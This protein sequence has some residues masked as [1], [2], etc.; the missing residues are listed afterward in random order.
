MVAVIDP[1]SNGLVASLAR[2][3]ANVTGITFEV[4]REQAGKNLELLKEAVPTVSRVAILRN[5]NVR[6]HMAY[7]NEAERAAKRLGVTIQFAEM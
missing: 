5:P 4:T 1:V 3:G 2:P 6:T 7:S